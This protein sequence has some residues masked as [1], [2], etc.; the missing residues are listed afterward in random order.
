MKSKPVCQGNGRCVNEPED[1]CETCIVFLRDWS[2]AGGRAGALA[3][4][5]AMVEKQSKDDWFRGDIVTAERLRDL[6]LE[7]HKL[8]EAAGR[9]LDKFIT[10]S[11]KKPS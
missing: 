8:R 11:L 7:I 6:A 3:E 2:S 5:Y 1:A 10:A 4:I 9:E